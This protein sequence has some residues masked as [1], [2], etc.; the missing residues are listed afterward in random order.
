MACK[1][2]TKDE[3]PGPTTVYN[4]S[5]A[6][7]VP[8]HSRGRLPKKV[9]MKTWSLH[10]SSGQ[11]PTLW[12]ADLHVNSFRSDLIFGSV[13]LISKP[14]PVEEGRFGQNIHKR[15]DDKLKGKKQS[16]SLKGQFT[17]I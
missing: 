5:S 9:L 3:Q 12:P 6:A 4:R 11:S 8:L 10:A 13:P 14:S 15:T 16:G 7:S 2:E 17:Q 1:A